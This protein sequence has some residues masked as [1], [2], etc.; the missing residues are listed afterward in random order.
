MK[1]IPSFRFK[2]EKKYFFQNRIFLPFEL[3]DK[4]TFLKNLEILV[5]L[6]MIRNIKDFEIKIHP[7]GLKLKE[8]IEF[9]R[10]IRQMIK[11]NKIS[12]N[13]KDK[14]NS[15][16]IG[17]TTAIIVALESNFKCYH[18]CSNP[19]FDSYSPKLW[20]S[21]TVKKLSNNLFLYELKKKNSFIKKGYNNEKIF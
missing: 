3:D 1:I 13:L 9:A 14:N 2:N 8:H 19:I 7:L 18:V 12:N 4:I 17:Q 16:F 10:N 20:T 15:I 21:L 5:K 11:K 6:N